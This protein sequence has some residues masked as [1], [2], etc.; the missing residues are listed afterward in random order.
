MNPANDINP[1]ADEDGVANACGPNNDRTACDLFTDSMPIVDYR[2]RTVSITATA[3]DSVGA[4]VDIVSPADKNPSTARHD[5]VLT[6]G[7]TTEIEVMVT[8]EDTSVTRTFTASVYRKNLNPSDDATLSS[9]ELSDATLMP[10]FASDT[11][12]YTANAA[13]ST[14]QVTVSATTND[15]AG[16]ARVAY[17]SGAGTMADPFMPGTGDDDEMMAGHQVALG[18]PGS[19]TD[20]TVQ[21]T[22][23]D[24]T[25]D[26]YTITVTRAEEGGMDASLTSLSLTDGDGMDVALVAGVAAHWNTLDCPE[27]ND[28]VGADDQPDD[29]NSPY[30]KM[31]DGLDDAAKAVVDQTYTDDPIEGFMSNIGM[32]YAMVASDVD[33]VTVS[34]MAM[35][36]ATVSGDVGA[37]SLDV[38]G[39]TITVTVTAEDEDDN[40]DLHGHGD[41]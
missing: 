34:A 33:M 32:Y 23:E 37:V 10:D 14:T 26:H 9:L 25:E 38:G 28:R 16:G 18:A 2:V 41:P 13:F 40:D 1:A 22:A 17:G 30:C 35:L 20:I 39:N 24:G 6:A 19:D 27:M 21:V 31:Y 12:G 4:V 36:G 11:M 3:N 29:M 7:Q 8:A 15:D 5:I